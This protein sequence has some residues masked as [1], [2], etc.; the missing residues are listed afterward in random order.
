MKKNIQVITLGSIT[1]DVFVL[2]NEAQILK[3]NK[4]TCEKLLAFEYG[5]KIPVG[6]IR[7]SIGGASANVAIGLK[8]LGIESAP[9]VTFGGDEIGEKLREKLEK[10]KINT[11]LCQIVHMKDSDRSIILVDPISRDRTIFYSREAGSHLKLKQISQWKADWVFVSSLALG[12]EKKLSQILKLRLLRGTRIAF[13][14]GKSQLASGLKFLSPFL[15]ETSVLFLN[16]DEALELALS[17]KEFRQKYSE[18]PPKKEEV[19]KLF[20]EIGVKIVVITLGKKGAIASDS[21]YLYR[22]PGASPKA[23][24]LTGAGDAFASG[25]LASWILEEGNMKK[26]MGFGMANASE[27]IMY[28]GAEKGLL[29]LSQMKKKINEVVLE[30]VIKEKRIKI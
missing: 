16:W 28:F 30:N 18:K 20:H 9:C 8:K 7:T 22:S 3:G 14:P 6:K 29:S 15:K 10:E 4:A 27:V 12:W 21:Y 19:I 11:E 24:E 5:A 25:F 23:V 17:D 2:V 1:E 13:N 26:A